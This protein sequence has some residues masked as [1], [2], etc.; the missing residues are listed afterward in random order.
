MMPAAKGGFDK[1]AKAPPPPAAPATPPPAITQA[2]TPAS[3]NP[4]AEGTNYRYRV[5]LIASGSAPVPNF[6]WL[7]TQACAE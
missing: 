3:R 6:G 5:V 7:C 1:N 2:G 4:S